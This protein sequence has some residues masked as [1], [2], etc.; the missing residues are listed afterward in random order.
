VSTIDK[1]GYEAWLTSS[2]SADG[3][4]IASSVRT[5]YEG[6][7]QSHVIIADGTT[8]QKLVTIKGLKGDPG[9]A[10]FSPDGKQLAA[11]VG[12]RRRAGMPMPVGTLIVWD[13]Q[14]GKELRLIPG[15][16]GYNLRPAFSPDGTRIAAASQADGDSLERVVK[17]WEIASGRLVASF[18][19]AITLE[20]HG[21][22]LS[23]SPDGQA[24]AAD[25]WLPLG[26][27]EL[28]VW[29][30][31][32]GR[33]RFAIHRQS[34]LS[35]AKAAFSP[36]SRRIACSLSDFQLAVWDAADGKELALYQGHL[37]RLNSLAF[38]R[39]G[40][41]LLSVDGLGTVKVWDAQTGTGPRTLNVQGLP[42]CS[43]MSPDGRKIANWTE[44]GSSAGVQVWDST[45]RLLLSLKRSTTRENEGY[46][47]R[48]LHWSARGE[49][50]AYATTNLYQ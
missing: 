39:D 19:T 28:R 37:G 49:R 27:S 31:K 3:T 42:L 21:I 10:V 48:T 12:P 36:D 9:T 22:S 6:D 43:A 41:N 16:T 33:S 40:R 7:G 32:T 11:A 24:L 25:G 29:D 8:G 14:T 30:M 46:H 38:S 47:S 2:L 44:Q 15:I 4:R 17:V 5:K 50:L 34:R 23:F 1:S 18:P 26:G 13:T 20:V 35:S 45:G